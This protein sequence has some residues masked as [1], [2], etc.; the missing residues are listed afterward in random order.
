MISQIRIYAFALRLGLFLY[1]SAVVLD[2]FYYPEYLF[3]LAAVRAAVSLA[4]LGLYILLFRVKER[5]QFMII[6]SAGLVTSFGLSFICF[7][8]GDGF[9]S[10]YFVGLAQAIMVTTILFNLK[11]RYIVLI[12]TLM[13]GQHFLLLMFIP[14][15][16]MDLLHNLFSLGIISIIVGFIHYFIYSLAREIKEIRGILPICSAC[17]KIRNDEGGWEQIEKYIRD[18]SEAEFSHGICPDCAKKLYSEFL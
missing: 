15:N 11:P 3:E 2:Y 18:R 12:L 1:P 16:Y 7:V 17:K 9:R 8:T 4:L 5:N 6:V 14:W 13:L 10:P